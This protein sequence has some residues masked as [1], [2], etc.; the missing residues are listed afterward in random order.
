M[1]S[2]STNRR[3]WLKGWAVGSRTERTRGMCWGRRG[4]FTWCCREQST[5]LKWAKS[6]HSLFWRG[7]EPLMSRWQ[8]RTSFSSRVK[9]HR[10]SDL[11]WTWSREW[12]R[13]WLRLVGQIGML[14]NGKSLVWEFGCSA[15]GKSALPWTKWFWKV[16]WHCYRSLQITVQRRAHTL[17]D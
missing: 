12:R 4:I 9:G 16:A 13:R 2:S 15:S 3:N 6:R 14:W 1:R 7:R 5:P 11:F 10:L 17:R 8:Q